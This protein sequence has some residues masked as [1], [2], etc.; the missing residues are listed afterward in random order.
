M[1]VD[2]AELSYLT[3]RLF[4]FARM[5]PEAETIPYVKPTR[6][7]LEEALDRDFDVKLLLE[8]DPI[9]DRIARAMRQRFPG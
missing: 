1:I 9:H 6:G 5:E 7:D 4:R 8:E 3:T 2:L